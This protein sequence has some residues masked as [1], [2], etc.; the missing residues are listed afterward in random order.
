L[1]LVP[2]HRQ[3][4]W[5]M[6]IISLRKDGLEQPPHYESVHKEENLDSKIFVYGSAS[7]IR[8]ILL[9]HGLQNDYINHMFEEAA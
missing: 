8:P 5:D 3:K 1:L 7:E 4:G 6:N 2:E 9:S